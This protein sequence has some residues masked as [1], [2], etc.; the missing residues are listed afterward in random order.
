MQHLLLVLVPAT[1]AGALSGGLTAWFVLRKFQSRQNAKP[2]IPSGQRLT[3]D[4]DSAAAAWAMAHGRPEAAG[5]VADKLRALHHIAHR[6][7]WR[8]S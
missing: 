8:Q 1:A 3:P 2:T 6:R 5:L 7:G 4:I